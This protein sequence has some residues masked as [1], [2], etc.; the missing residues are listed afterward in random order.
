MNSLKNNESNIKDVAVQSSEEPKGKARSTTR[1]DVSASDK[2][3]IEFLLECEPYQ[4]D[5]VRAI[6]VLAADKSKP[7]AFNDGDA[8]YVNRFLN[9]G[10][11][12]SKL[13]SV[14]DL[15]THRRARMNKLLTSTNRFCEHGDMQ[16]VMMAVMNLAI[17]TTAG[18]A[19]YDFIR[20]QAVNH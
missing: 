15:M 6:A 17:D 18:K 7:F 14:E 4:A 2:R 16:R 11:E 10:V 19:A 13:N 8:T 12:P 1:S 3:I 20:K 9:S 5:A